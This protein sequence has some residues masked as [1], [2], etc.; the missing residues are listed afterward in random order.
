MSF[1]IIPLIYGVILF[2]DY[3]FTAPH[4]APRHERILYLSLVVLAAIV[5]IPTSYALT[6]DHVGASLSGLISLFNI[7]G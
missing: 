4:S 3:H 5:S 1:I 2:A 6:L 7:G